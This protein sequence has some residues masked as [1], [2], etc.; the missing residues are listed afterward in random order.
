MHSLQ[1]IKIIK[2]LYQI[3]GAFLDVYEEQ[4]WDSSLVEIWVL[5][6]QPSVS[7]CTWSGTEIK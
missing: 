3:L 2:Q 4:R 6:L 7:L 1:S 5:H